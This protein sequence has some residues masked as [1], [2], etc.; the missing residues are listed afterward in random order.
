M[1]Q[2]T[3][4]V[5]EDE[6]QI[7]RFVRGALEAEGWQVHEAGN[8]RDGLAAAGTRQP[9]LLVLDLGLPDGDGVTLI[10]DVRGW[11]AVPIIVLSART[12]EADKIAAL[13]AG[14]DDYLTKPFGTGELLARVRANLR[15]PRAAGGNG[16]EPEA[17]FRFGEIELDRAARIVRRAG[18][19][20]HLT[21]TEYRLLAVLVANAG[22][23]LTQRQLLRE[24]WG[25]SHS[26]QSHYLRIY[27]GHLRQKLEADP[28]Q[29]KHLLTETAVG[30]RLVV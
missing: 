11:S 30:Y 24:V 6:P 7:R 13:D 25:P 21:P 27:M 4:I 17:V 23:V 26:E 16:D 22:R 12:D 14:A 8:L 28:A 1:P 20:V 29:P 5:I 10:R 18:A 15:R 9:D 19:E 2:P 3:A